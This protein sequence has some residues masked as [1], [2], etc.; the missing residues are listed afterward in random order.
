MHNRYK[1]N[2]NLARFYR[3]FGDAPVRRAFWQVKI[4]INDI[5]KGKKICHEFTRL[6]NIVLGVIPNQNWCE[7]PV[8]KMKNEVKG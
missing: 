7:F 3:N 8:G 4:K 1:D 6:S 2:E 5:E